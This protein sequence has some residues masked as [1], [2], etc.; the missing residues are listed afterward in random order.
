MQH[1]NSR[2][3]AGND[4]G[5]Q[6]ANGVIISFAAA[7]DIVAALRMLD[8]LAR[9]RGAQL[10]PRHIELTEQLDRA[11][12]VERRDATTTRLDAMVT[13][14]LSVPS[15]TALSPKQAAVILG[16][17]PD[18]VRALC[19]RGSLAAWRSGDRWSINAESVV[20]Y[21]RRSLGED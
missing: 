15:S 20:M 7:A 2:P 10:G 17:A 4:V 5:V 18:S 8:H 1:G 12:R 14:L 11:S 6:P 3:M 9:D 16:I 19:R 21:K 13:D